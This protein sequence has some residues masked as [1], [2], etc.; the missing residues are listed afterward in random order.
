M[1][2]EKHVIKNRSNETMMRKSSDKYRLKSSHCF[3]ARSQ[4]SFR[5]LIE[6][7][8]SG[9]EQGIVFEKVANLRELRARSRP[10]TA[11]GPPA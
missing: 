11:L 1:S 7:W 3:S 10:D 5:R 6:Q 4:C 9:N 8:R 2:A